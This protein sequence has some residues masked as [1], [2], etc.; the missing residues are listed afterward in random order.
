LED[1]AVVS[2]SGGG[3]V[4]DR[5]HIVLRLPG[6]VVPV[7]QRVGLDQIGQ[8]VKRGSEC[9]EWEL[10]TALGLALQHGDNCAEQ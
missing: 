5:K 8:G 6:V 7:C 9:R 2:V 4:E 10:A 1:G 3:S